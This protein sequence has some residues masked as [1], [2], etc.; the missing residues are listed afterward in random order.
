MNDSDTS[1][2]FHGIFSCVAIPSSAVKIASSR[3]LSSVAN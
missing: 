2:N 1:S 3:L